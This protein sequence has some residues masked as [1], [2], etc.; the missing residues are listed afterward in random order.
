MSTAVLNPPAPA[1]TVPSTGANR[2]EN[3]VVALEAWEYE[4]ACGVGIRRFTANWKTADKPSY[5]NDRKQDERTASVAAAV[6][7]MAVAKHL[8]LYWSG[9]VWPASQ[10]HRF[11]HLPDVEPGIEVRRVRA[12]TNKA[13]VRAKDLDKGL[14]LVVAYPIPDEF[15]EVE[16]LGWL[17]CED[18]WEIGS[19]SAYDSYDSTRVVTATQ[20]HHIDSIRDAMPTPRRAHR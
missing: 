13:A 4:H 14:S 20:L 10:H 8:G 7:E 19:A 3:P 18:A 11:K 1:T 5:R 17:T 15:R 16:I 2:P 9:H 6:A 12:R